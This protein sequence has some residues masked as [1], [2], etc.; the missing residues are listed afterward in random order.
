MSAPGRPSGGDRRGDEPDR[1]PHARRDGRAMNEAARKRLLTPL[2]DE[3]AR[4]LRLV[5]PAEIDA[6]LRRA[7][8]ELEPWRR[9]RIRP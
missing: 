8:Q 5:T 1:G 2:A 9:R 3:Q 4:D 6:A 7:D